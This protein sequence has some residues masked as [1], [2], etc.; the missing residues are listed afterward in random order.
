MNPPM[1]ASLLIFAALC[2]PTG[3]NAAAA[4]QPWMRGDNPQGLYVLISV[5]E[6]CPVRST[7]AD[8]AVQAAFSGAG[9]RRASGWAPGELF[10]T[11]EIDCA[12]T[13]NYPDIFLYVS[14]VAFAVNYQEQPAYLMQYVK[15][16][17]ESFGIDTLGNIE[18]VLT[19]GVAAALADYAAAN[20]RGTEGA[21]DG[22]GRAQ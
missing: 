3:P 14:R 19:D 6:E 11:A 1:R 8:L 16:R 10:L 15:S 20:G 9:M 4:P 5:S 17:H 13:T 2:L 18:Q 12:P 22:E 21:G 7:E